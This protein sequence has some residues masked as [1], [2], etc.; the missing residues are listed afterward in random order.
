[1]RPPGFLRSLPAPIVTASLLVLL[2]IAVGFWGQRATGKPTEQIAQI[3][4]T[5]A[6]LSDGDCEFAADVR[7]ASRWSGWAFSLRENAVR[8]ALV[9]LLRSKSH[10]MVATNTARE[11]LRVQMLDAVNSVIGSGRATDLHITEFEFL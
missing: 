10:Y 5:R 4:R 9:A 11:A 6:R 7:L 2:A 8:N 3:A 1:M